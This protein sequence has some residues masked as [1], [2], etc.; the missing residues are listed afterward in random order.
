MRR[1][2]DKDSR[3]KNFTLLFDTFRSLRIGFDSNIVGQIIDGKEGVSKKILY[4]L[5]MVKDALM[6][7]L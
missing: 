1:R 3:L 4:E 7:Q 2:D 6:Q 5:K